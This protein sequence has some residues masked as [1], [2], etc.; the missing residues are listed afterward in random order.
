MWCG[1]VG[2]RGNIMREGGREGEKASCCWEGGEC[3]RWGKE[4]DVHEIHDSRR[5]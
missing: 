4:K 2:E 3:G 1:R 5:M